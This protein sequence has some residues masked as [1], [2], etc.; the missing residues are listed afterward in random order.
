MVAYEAILIDQ[1]IASGGLSC[2]TWLVQP[3]QGA[4]WPVGDSNNIPRARKCATA[5]ENI[6]AFF[7]RMGAFVH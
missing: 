4:R 1:F 2:A 7:A 5:E 3:R 6:M